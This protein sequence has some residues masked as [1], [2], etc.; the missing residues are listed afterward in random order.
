MA[1]NPGNLYFDEHD[2]I[3][4]DIAVNE[5]TGKECVR[6]TM[7][8]LNDDR[9][10][11]ESRYW[12]FEAEEALSWAETILHNAR[13]LLQRKRLNPPNESGGGRT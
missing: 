11:R 7:V 4:V 10:V 6:I 12:F 8:W 2:N 5:N 13:A 3:K 9:T 1:D